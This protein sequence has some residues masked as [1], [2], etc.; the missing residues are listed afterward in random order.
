MLWYTV[1]RIYA[2]LNL[3]GRKTR[4]LRP[5]IYARREITDELVKTIVPKTRGAIIQISVDEGTAR[6]T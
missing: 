2:H 1:T 6:S 5:S 4:D 3:V